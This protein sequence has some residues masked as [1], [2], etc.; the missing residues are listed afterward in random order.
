MRNINNKLGQERAD[1]LQQLLN[2]AQT[3][4]NL[5][6]QESVINQIA[7]LVLRSRPLCRRFNGMPLTGVY[8]EI[9]DQVKQQLINHIQHQLTQKTINSKQIQPNYLYAMQVQI[10]KQ[11]L[12]DNYLKKLGLSAQSHLINSE[13]RAYALTELIK[14]IKL[15]ERLCRPHINKFSHSLYLM[16]YEEALA[17]TLAYVCLNIDLYDPNRGNKK[18]INWVNFKLDKFLLK[19]YGQYSKYTEHLLPSF[20]DLEQVSQPSVSLNLPQ[21][22]SQYIEQDPKQIFAKTHIRNRP[23][24]NFSRIALAKFADQSWSDISQEVDIPIATL[25]SFYNRWCHRFT[26][27]LEAELKKYIYSL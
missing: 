10:F 19:C 5:K 6:H 26:P 2:Q 27:L 4:N 8:Q 23:D 11:I 21:L 18:F 9:Y 16:L 24:V 22:L 3:T 12:D 1:L 20:D 25:S 17:E 14:A 13:L 7:A 15:S